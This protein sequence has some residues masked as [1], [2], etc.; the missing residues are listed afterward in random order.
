MRVL[1]TL[2]C[3]QCKRRNYNTTKNKRT[4]PEK[5]SF[6]KHCR[7]CNAHTEHKETK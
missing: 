5:L 1:V 6:R 7:F 3:S 2:A 4:T